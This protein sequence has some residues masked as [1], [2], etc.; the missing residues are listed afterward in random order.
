MRFAGIT[1]SLKVKKILE[2]ESVKATSMQ[3]ASK[4]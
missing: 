1:A 2:K 3:K 4:K